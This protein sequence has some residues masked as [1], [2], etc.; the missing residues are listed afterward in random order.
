MTIR[1]HLQK[2]F[3]DPDGSYSIPELVATGAALLGAGEQAWDFFMRAQHFDGQAFGIGV[4]AL[5]V[6]L[7]SAQRIRDG[8]SK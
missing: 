4:G 5:V 3:F 2:T 1:E 7:G 6:A 8:A